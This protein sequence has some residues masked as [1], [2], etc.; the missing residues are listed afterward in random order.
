VSGALVNLLGTVQTGDGSE[1]AWTAA[2]KQQLVG[3]ND[4]LRTDAGSAATVVFFDVSTIDV[5]E[6]SEIH[7]V[8]ASRNQQA[9]KGRLTV[10]MTTGL[11]RVRM[12]RF[13]NP[14]SEF[15]IETP[16]AST[17]IHGAQILVEVA[18]DTTTTVT[19][20]IGSATVT[21]GDSG[22]L[23]LIGGTQGVVITA[24]QQAMIDAN[25]IVTVSQA[26]EL[27]SG[28]L[29]EVVDQANS[30]SGQN[31]NV[32]VDEKIVNDFIALADT[33]LQ[34]FG[35]SSPTIWFSQ[36][37]VIVGGE[38]TRISGLPIKAAFTLVA[39]P[40]VDAGG[41]IGLSL[42]AANALGVSLPVNLVN[43]G[44]TLVEGSLQDMVTSPDVPVTIT[45]VAISEGSMT[46]VGTKASAGAGPPADGAAEDGSTATAS[47][48]PTSIGLI[49]LA[50][51]VLDADAEISGLA[52]FGDTLV[53]LP[54]YPSRE[55]D[56]LYT[57]EKWALLNFLTGNNSQ[58]LV[59]GT[60]RLTAP[61]LAGS[62]PGFEGYEA[63]EFAG[64]QVYMTIEAEQG[65]SMLGYLV[66]GSVSSGG[67]E[68]VI[69]TNNRAEI[70]P[71]SFVPNAADETVL[72]AGERILTFYEV[73]D[74][75]STP[76]PV[77]H[78][79]DAALQ[80]QNSIPFTNIDWR[81]TDATALDAANRF[82]VVNTSFDFAGV[83]QLIEFQLGDSGITPTGSA[84]IV[85]ELEAE[86]R[87]WEG[88]V[89]LDD[90]GF[91]IATDKDPGTTLAFVPGP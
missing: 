54:Q 59:P 19:V 82:W 39:T 85:L 74:A 71:Q 10:N 51:P 75:R 24:G 15:V 32:T 78:V 48:E 73:N 23:P 28:E 49:P 44:I 1:A 31:F 17:S 77:A 12:V 41:R 7:I 25:G 80:A 70:Q 88:V 55:G 8:E 18:P 22:G 30:A 4:W 37:D 36:E 87:N 46:V 81:V 61:G 52:W 57:I 34:D 56:V 5:G 27:L 63:I 14:G 35:L 11:M 60:M 13:V 89:R 76:S 45:S 20:D 79:F 91:L 3:A 29:D 43:R 40:T 72:I 66:A 64:D 50:G 83:E 62:I 9:T 86:P 47:V 65:D 58:A 6:N 38:L 90:H 21:T 67:N 33:G 16:T 2:V 84:P 53:L 42:K 26:Y 68:I 69:D